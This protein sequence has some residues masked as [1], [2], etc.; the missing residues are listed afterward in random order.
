M[1]IGTVVFFSATKGYGFI[2]SE[3][4]G[5]E[6]FV[7]VTAVKA[8]GLDVLRAGQQVS[9]QLL[10]ARNGKISAVDLALLA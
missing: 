4:D 5:S 7:H 3:D 9:Y 10:V 1:S 6:H 8:A 2:K